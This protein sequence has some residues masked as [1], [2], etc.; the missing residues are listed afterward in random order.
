[1]FILS[2][3]I[4]KNTSFIQVNDPILKH[5]LGLAFGLCKD[6]KAARAVE[7]REAIECSELV[8]VCD[9]ILNKKLK[10]LKK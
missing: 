4:I 3:V 8:R 5:H 9:L 2:S 7:G 10:K 1:M 6:C